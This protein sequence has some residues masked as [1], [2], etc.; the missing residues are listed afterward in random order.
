MS[1]PSSATIK[2]LRYS[3][4]T[5][6]VEVPDTIPSS[7]FDMAVMEYCSLTEDETLDT[8][9]LDIDATCLPGMIEGEPTNPEIAQF[10]K[11]VEAIRGEAH[12]ICFTRAQA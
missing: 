7:D 4:Q 3:V 1:T 10:F 6:Q 2:T 9:G 11:E 5:L 8:T 12:R